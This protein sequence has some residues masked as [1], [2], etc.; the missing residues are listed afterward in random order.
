MGALDA[1]NLANHYLGHRFSNLSGSWRGFQCER[2][3]IEFR[4]WFQA[5]VDKKPPTP[6]T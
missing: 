5:L 3:G 2:C 4:E 6:C 1:E